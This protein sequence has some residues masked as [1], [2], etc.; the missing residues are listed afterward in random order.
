MR[1][2]VY[3]L[4]LSCLFM[5]AAFS[6]SAPVV[7]TEDKLAVTVTPDQAQF[8]VKLKS[9]PTTGYSWFLRE[10]NDKLIK[11]IKQSYIP[12]DKKLIGSSGYQVW[13]FAVQKNAFTV[14]QQTMLHFIYARPWDVKEPS[15]ELIFKVST[16][17][18]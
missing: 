11:P 18:N 12:G 7:Y 17:S 1:Q 3:G 14:P 5:T 13:V 16:F 9:N 10:Y 8:M 6:A 15:S 4:L 2:L